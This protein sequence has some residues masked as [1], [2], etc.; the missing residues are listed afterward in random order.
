MWPK[1]LLEFLPHLS[2]LI[3]AADS[4][5]SSRKEAEK[6]QAAAI[7]SIADEVRGGLSKAA[8]DQAVFRREFQTHV[9]ASVQ[10]AADAAGAR[11]GV[12]NLEARF[13]TLEKR[14]TTMSRLLWI[15]LLTLAVVL[16][17][18]ALRAFR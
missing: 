5:L 11:T 18:V 14:L 2:R 17:L 15:T 12:E 13:Q 9:A 8:E 10:V 6:A 16:V 1:L 3:P 4:F 7:A